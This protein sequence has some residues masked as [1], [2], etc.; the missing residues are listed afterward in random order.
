M[1]PRAAFPS[2]SGRRMAFVCAL[3]LAMVL[4]DQ[5]R[6]AVR[7]AEPAL[8]ALGEGAPVYFM[9]RAEH[10]HELLRRL[11]LDGASGIGE[12]Q[13]RLRT[14][15]FDPQVLALTG[16]DVEGKLS[17]S[18][19]EPMPG[20]G[21]L[22]HRLAL[23]LAAPLRFSALLE[24]AA[25]AQEVPLHLVPEGSPL[26]AAGGYAIY[27][28]EGV[29]ALLRLTDQLLIVDVATSWGGRLPS[30]LE[31]ARLY[32]LRARVP[33]TI[34]VPGGA[35][36]AR[37]LLPG[38][39]VALYVDGR[40][41]S[42][43]A[44]WASSARARNGARQRSLA[45]PSPT[46]SLQ[47][48]AA[49]GR[50]PAAF[51][52]LALIVELHARRLELQI[53]WG[54]S[55]V[56][57]GLLSLPV[58][59]D[60]ALEPAHLGRDAT[61]TLSL[62][63]ASFAPFRELHRDGPLQD[64]PTL[65]QALEQCPLLGPA[66]VAVRHW[67]QALGTL[68]ELGSF[69]ETEALKPL[70]DIFRTQLR[71]LDV[72]VRG[73]EAG[74]LSYA[75]AAT[76]P[77]AARPVLEVSLTGTVPPELLDRGRR[78]LVLYPFTFAGPDGGVAALE[79]LS[80]DR[81]LLTLANSR[82][83]VDWASAAGD[84]ADMPGGVYMAGRGIYATGEGADT[85]RRPSLATPT[86]P[87]LLRA[88]LRGSRLRQLATLPGTGTLLGTALDAVSRLGSVEAELTAHR[89]LLLLDMRATPP[90]P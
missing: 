49:W 23:P 7:G 25:L 29:I 28:G 44:T 52:D 81:L 70:V 4:P 85:T 17:L 47:C 40:A 75:L 36:G 42:A 46:P 67:P 88:Q 64:L 3:A 41:L 35:Q 6:A 11:G 80:G 59:D 62:R 38:A 2:I 32:P 72:L 24:R 22:H 83:S 19:F 55:A 69:R 45:S 68:F 8:L 39:A 16:I 82:R 12:L 61:A 53:G 48:L 34:Y 87:I 15:L 57:Q 60:A 20:R 13:R 18:A 10:A 5:A 30:A 89:D 54:T 71:N 51:D 90:L 21:C 27:S 37:R 50:A 43:L 14:D 63:L 66:L 86:V 26:A 9:A 84:G 73:V 65:R 79:A 77:M 31:L 76:F 33:F 58:S 78:R 1:T 56:G 74:R